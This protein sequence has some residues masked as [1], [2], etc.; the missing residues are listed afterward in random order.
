MTER[1]LRFQIGRDGAPAT[2]Y[3]AGDL[4]IATARDIE[5]AVAAA[6]D[7]RSEEFPPGRQRTGSD[8][9]LLTSAEVADLFGV[10]RTTVVMWAKRRRIPVL[11]TPGGQLR[12]RAHE[13][14][15]LLGRTEDDEGG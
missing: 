6:L 14:L 9:D 13:I 15:S 12:F 1:L 3:V 4:D 5:H 7:A 11:R 8:D 2:L 10:D